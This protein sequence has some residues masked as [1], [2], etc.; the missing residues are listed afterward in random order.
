MDEKTTVDNKRF[1]KFQK[2][3]DPDILTYKILCSLYVIMTY[4]NIYYVFGKESCKESDFQRGRQSCYNI[5]TS[6]QQL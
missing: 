3:F 1:Q 2:P 6:I 5:F 4:L